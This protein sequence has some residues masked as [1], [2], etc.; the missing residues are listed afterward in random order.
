MYRTRR[1]S[2]CILLTLCCL[3]GTTVGFAGGGGQPTVQPYTS[4]TVGSRVDLFLE[5]RNSGALYIFADHATCPPCILAVGDVVRHAASRHV[6]RR[7]IMTD[8]GPDEVARYGQDHAWAVAAVADEIG[9]YWERYGVRRGPVCMVIDTDGLVRYVGIPGTAFFD[10][11]RCNAAI[12]AI[13]ARSTPQWSYADTTSER[14]S[15]TVALPLDDTTATQ[16]YRRTRALY[17]ADRGTYVIHD[18]VRRQFSVVDTMATSRLRTVAQPVNVP[19]TAST[20]FMTRTTDHPS[21]IHVVDND[22]RTVQRYHGVFDIATGRM[23][24]L[25]FV[26][27]PS[28]AIKVLYSP[29]G[30]SII[31]PRNVCGPTRMHDP[32]VPAWWVYRDSVWAA[33]GHFDPWYFRSYSCSFMWWITTIVPG[34]AVLYQSYSDTIVEV[35][36]EGAVRRS[37]LVTIPEHLRIDIDDRLASI[38]ERSAAAQLAPIIDSSTRPYNMLYDAVWDVLYLTITVPLAYVRPDMAARAEHGT[39]GYLLPFDRRTGR[40][41]PTIA[42]PLYSQP[43]AVHDG[44]VHSLCDDRGRVSVARGPIPGRYRTNNPSATGHRR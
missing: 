6:A 9:V 44:I 31:V 14:L 18:L 16:S 43:F 2:I 20:T 34:G 35:D 37:Y 24:I 33:K 5:D 38:D 30:R 13:H 26:D 42:V 36:W 10:V 7:L 8:V 15:Y 1:S 12:D 39:A 21:R 29:D 22:Y 40:Q 19:Y 4:T 41:L 11:D 23:D 25:P 27:D 32:D 17:D 28:A 3:A